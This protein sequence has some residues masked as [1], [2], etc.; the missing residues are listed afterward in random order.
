MTINRCT[1][2]YLIVVPVDVVLAVLIVVVKLNSKVESSVLE[3]FESIEVG[4]IVISR[5]SVSS[6]ADTDN[7][8]N[9]NKIKEIAQILYHIIVI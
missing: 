6:T 5:G 7:I 9:R 4:S 1:I 3:R 8:R 2:E